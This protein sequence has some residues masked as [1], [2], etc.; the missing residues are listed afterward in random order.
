[1][2]RREYLVDAKL[3]EEQE[4]SAVY[5]ALNKVLHVFGVCGKLPRCCERVGA[6]CWFDVFS[7]PFVK[8]RFRFGYADGTGLLTQSEAW[9]VCEGSVVLVLQ[10]V[11]L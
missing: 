11:D 4:C 5:F 2:S 7:G 1:M 9:L 3:G 6:G 8:Q 10:P